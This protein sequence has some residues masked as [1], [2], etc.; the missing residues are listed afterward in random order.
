MN[1]GDH[2]KI[3]RGFYS[4]HGIYIDRDQVVH[5]S[6]EPKRK[7]RSQIEVTT[8][9][10]FINGA[11]ETHL[12]VVEYEEDTIFDAETTIQLALE[13]LGDADYH[14]VFRNCEH[15]ATYCKTGKRESK[16]VKRAIIS[17]PSTGVI[18]ASLAAGIYYLNKNLTK[19]SK[20]S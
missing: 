8:L 3:G 14:I 19:K 9:E 6:G 2:I 10:K 12:K 7:N 1:R 11:K 5:F 13:S 17:L 20:K 15:F 4:H 18:A 16:Q